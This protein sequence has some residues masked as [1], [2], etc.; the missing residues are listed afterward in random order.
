M[1]V[2]EI[3]TELI[4][5]SEVGVCRRSHR[6]DGLK[7]EMFLCLFTRLSSDH[8]AVGWRE[9]RSRMWRAASGWRGGSR[10]PRFVTTHTHRWQHFSQVRLETT[11]CIFLF[12]IILSGPCGLFSVG[13]LHGNSWLTGPSVCRISCHTLGTHAQSYKQTYNPSRIML[14]RDNNSTIIR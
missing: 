13:N 3:K 5:P 7:T 9:V 1:F 2:N 12:K 4:C 6:S 8:R 10:L 14:G 11:L